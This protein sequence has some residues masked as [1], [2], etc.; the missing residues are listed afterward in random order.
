MKNANLVPQILNAL[1]N[2][3]NEDL[4]FELAEIGLEELGKVVAREEK[5]K[6]E[7]KGGNR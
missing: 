2:T 7:K 5:E 3:D 4:V 6:E 1:K